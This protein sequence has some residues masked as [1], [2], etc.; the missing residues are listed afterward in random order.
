MAKEETALIEAPKFEIFE[1]GFST[2][3]I[4]ENIGDTISPS[5][6][7][8]IKVPSG[9]MTMWEVPT[10]EGH[11]N[12]K[13]IEG[14]IVYWKDVRAFWA[15]EY[16]GESV[17][18]DCF[19]DDNKN[20]TGDP[21]GSCAE[22]P[23]AQ[24]GTAKGGEGAGQA[25]K[26]MRLLFMVGKEDML[27]FVVGVPPTSIKPMKQYFLRLA[28]KKTAYHGVVTK[29]ALAKDKNAKGVE[30]SKIVPAVGEILPPE[31]RQ[32]SKEYSHNIR[33]VLDAAA[34]GI[35]QDHQGEDS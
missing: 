2:E 22:C 27:P 11:E 12:V 32:S 31:Q 14:I 18:P 8:R 28:T 35:V 17:P 3:V 5:D 33:P 10:L 16:D 34:Q 6:L 29:L 13:E 25:C 7:D 24:Y 26:L 21:G 4:Q 30:Y 1:P 15:K 19:A 23:H 9:G 20:G